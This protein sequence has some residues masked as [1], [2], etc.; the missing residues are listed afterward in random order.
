M[1]DIVLAWL[2]GHG[3]SIALFVIIA[4]LFI[5]SLPSIVE[6]SRAEQLRITETSLRRA[7]ISCYALEGRYPPDVEYLRKEYGL[8]LNDKKYIVHYD[9]FAENIMPEITVLER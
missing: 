9:I 7:V 2:R 6:S 4:T 8:Q 5:S 1:K 3:I